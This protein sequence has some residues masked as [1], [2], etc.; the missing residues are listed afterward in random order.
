MISIVVMS[1]LTLLAVGVMTRPWWRR[2]DVQLTQRRAANVTVYQTRLAEIDADQAAG[3]IEAEVAKTLR[4]ELAARLLSDAEGLA[5]SSATARPSRLWLLALLLPVF[6]A[7]WYWLQG[8]WRTQQVLELAQSDPAAA[9]KMSVD[10]M[11]GKLAARLADEPNDAEGWAML[12]RSYSVMQ[13]YAEGAMAYGKANE[14]S[15]AQNPDWLLGEGEAAAMANDRDLQGR[16]AAL[17]EAAIKLQPN[18]IGA[19]WYAGLAHAQAGDYAKTREYF[20]RLQSLE[21]PPDLREILEVRM[22]ELARLTGAATS[23]PTTP[24]KTAV[25]TTVI[26]I[27]L[28]IAPELRAQGAGRTLFVFAKAESGPPMPLAVQRLTQF[29]LPMTLQLDDSMGVMPTMKLS[30]FNRWVVTARLTRSGSAQAESGDLEGSVTVAR[31]A[32]AQPVNLRIERQIP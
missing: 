30:Q 15:G 31:E 12:G 24:A 11:V 10:D 23:A 13:R 25:Q 14:L 4:D 28:D 5:P 18:N 22:Q 19:L 3:L 6:A 16:P 17:F 2:Q 1:V 20:S 21:L 7:G 8:S 29:Q 27:A 9:Q 32:L 26:S